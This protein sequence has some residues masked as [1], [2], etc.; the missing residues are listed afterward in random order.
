MPESLKMSYFTS[1]D[2]EMS[3]QSMDFCEATFVPNS[4]VPTGRS[5][6]ISVD[7]VAGNFGSNCDF[8]RLFLG[9][10]QFSVFFND[11]SELACISLIGQSVV[12]L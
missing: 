11:E 8:L 3:F 10:F 2:I 12:Q 6:G 7:L 9:V 4:V 5:S 1:L